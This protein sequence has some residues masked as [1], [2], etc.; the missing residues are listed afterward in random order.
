MR[1]N[2]AVVLICMTMFWVLPVVAQ[3]SDP[4]LQEELQWNDPDLQR[5]ISR[6]L[7][8][9]D[10]VQIALEKNLPLEIARME[11]QVASEGVTAQWGDWM[12]GVELST[13]RTSAR[14]KALGDTLNVLEWTENTLTVAGAAF[15]TVCW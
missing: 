10:C 5:R 14:V 4:Q 15:S 9:D 8:L 3:V 2:S 12:P 6:P 11:R 7:T 1:L 13:M